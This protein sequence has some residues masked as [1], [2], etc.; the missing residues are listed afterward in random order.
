MIA[1]RTV[2][3]AVALF[4][5]CP[6]NEPAIAAAPQPES[7][8]AS[9]PTEPARTQPT[10]PAPAPTPTVVEAPPTEPAP[11]SPAGTSGA[12]S[13]DD[14]EGKSRAELVAKWGEPDDKGRATWTYRFPR[15]PAC[16][17]REIVYVLTLKGDRVTAVD[18]SIRQT[19]K[20]C[21]GEY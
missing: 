12:A 14:F 16:T 8:P 19:G 1:A 20:H 6:R 3:V 11:P 10:T 4:A 2:F 5:G 21:G 18:R 13:I 7:P 9:Q 15:P 17:D